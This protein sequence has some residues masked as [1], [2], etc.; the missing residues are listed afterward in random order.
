MV[1]EAGGGRGHR[2]VRPRDVSCS[3][4]LVR[5]RLLARGGQPDT[6]LLGR[7]LV[8]AVVCLRASARVGSCADCKDVRI[9]HSRNHVAP[10]RRNRTTRTLTGQSGSSAL[11]HAGWSG[12]QHRDCSRTVRRPGLDRPMG[13]ARPREPHRRALSRAID[14]GEH[15]AGRLQ[16]A[17]GVSNGRRPSAARVARHAYGSRASHA[18]CREARSRHG[19]SC[20]PSSGGSRIQSCC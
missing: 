2:G 8:P 11:D 7:Q 1:V 14:A 17:A 3:G 9:R 20:S 12:R 10:H 13:A 4:R 6:R 19:E 16:H 18:H 5:V 15:V